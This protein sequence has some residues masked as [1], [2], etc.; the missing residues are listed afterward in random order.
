MVDIPSARIRFNEIK[1]KGIYTMFVNGRFYGSGDLLYMKEL[2]AT[3]VVTCGMY[4]KDEVTFKI[5]KKERV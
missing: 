3:Y 4:D 1:D 2:F 5:E